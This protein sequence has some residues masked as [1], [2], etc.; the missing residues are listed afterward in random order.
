MCFLFLNKTDSVCH[1]FS[2]ESIRNRNDV[3][4]LTPEPSCVPD[5]PVWYS[6][7]PLAVE[8]MNKMLSRIRVVRE[9]QETQLNQAPAGAPAA[10]AAT[11]FGWL[12]DWHHCY[13]TPQHVDRCH[14]ETVV[15]KVTQCLCSTRSFW[16]R[17]RVPTLPSKY[18]NFLSEFKAL[19]VFENKAGA[20]KYL[21][22]MI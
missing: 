14:T 19:K 21:N 3:F 5:S 16:G 22:L 15:L 10:V 18:W 2:P 20:W 1:C 6:A 7:Q 4:Y 9:I 8:A 12:P 11:V 13:V 17:R